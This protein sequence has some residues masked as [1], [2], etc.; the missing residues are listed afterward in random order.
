MTA[1]RAPRMGLSLEPDVA[2]V[3][4]RT[5]SL[6]G[7]TETGVVTR[8]LSGHLGELMEYNDWL[9]SQEPGSKKQILGAN[10]MVSYGP[11]NLL[12]GI[13]SLDPDYQTD[14]ERFAAAVKSAE[15][16]PEWLARLNAAVA[17]KNAKG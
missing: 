14:A 3:L 1:P 7:V 15:L 6:T 9:A 8:I 10:L 16:D 4:K 2:A 17:A 11:S 13:K 12:A 5:S